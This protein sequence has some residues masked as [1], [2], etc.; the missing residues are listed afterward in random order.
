MNVPPG[1]RNRKQH[2]HL[3]HTMLLQQLVTLVIDDT[4]TDATDGYLLSCHIQ[5]IRLSMQ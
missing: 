3:E 4:A 2:Q 1:D 5:Q